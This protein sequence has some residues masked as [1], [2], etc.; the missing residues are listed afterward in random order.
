ML[1]KMGSWEELGMGWQNSEVREG[2]NLVLQDVCAK[3]LFS[4][5]KM[6]PLAFLS[7][8]SQ[9]FLESHLV[10]GAVSESTLHRILPTQHLTA[11][12]SLCEDAPYICR[13]TQPSK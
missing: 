5:S 8:K 1:F 7:R 13:R 12:H 3:S 4:F 9:E 2:F 11:K 10:S 6:H